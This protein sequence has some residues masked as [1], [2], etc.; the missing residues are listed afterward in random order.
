M[1]PWGHFHAPMRCYHNIS[2]SHKIIMSQYAWVCSL[3][4]VVIPPG[5]PSIKVDTTSLPHS[6]IEYENIPPPIPPQQFPPDDPALSPKLLE[7]RESQQS[8]RDAPPPRPPKSNQEDAAPPPRPPKAHQ[9]TAVSG[10]ALLIRILLDTAQLYFMAIVEESARV[11]VGICSEWF[12]STTAMKYITASVFVL[13]VPTEMFMYCWSLWMIGQSSS[14]ETQS[15]SASALVHVANFVQVTTTNFNKF[16]VLWGP[17]P[18]PCT[19]L[20]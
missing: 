11:L 4:S 2:V 19:F 13:P 1:L 12:S 6:P 10:Y 15:P 16:V 9:H 14:N 5:T 20:T 17:Q 18:P 3:K 8:E 7:S